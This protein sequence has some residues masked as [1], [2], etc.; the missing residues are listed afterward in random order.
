MLR[1]FAMQ[2]T[3]EAN[4]VCGSIHASDENVFCTAISDV[5]RTDIRLSALHCKEIIVQFAHA[6]CVSGILLPQYQ[7]AGVPR[8]FFC[9]HGWLPMLHKELCWYFTVLTWIYAKC[10]KKKNRIWFFKR[11]ILPLSDIRHERIRNVWDRFSWQFNSIVLP[12]MTLNVPCAHSKWIHRNYPV[13][14]KW[15]AFFMFW[16]YYG[17]KCAVSISWNMNFDC[18]VVITDDS[19][20]C[21]TV[22]TVAGIISGV[23]IFLVARMFIHFG[24]QDFWIKTACQFFEQT[25]F[26]CQLFCCHPVKINLIR[27]PVD[28]IFFF[29][30]SQHCTPP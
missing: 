13:V 7:Q 26:S 4:V 8:P 21:V 5:S 24:F 19:L 14:K 12:Q 3:R 2:K 23:V 28:D 30:F 1:V 17:L 11:T 16:N 6:K 22:S 10:V 25:V 29:S 20:R 27:Q 18:V 15:S 9:L